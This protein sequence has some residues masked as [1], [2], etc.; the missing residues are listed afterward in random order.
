[1]NDAL[2]IQNVWSGTEY[3]HLVEWSLPRHMRYCRIH[4]WDYRLEYGDA[5][6]RPTADPNSLAGWAKPHMILN[7]FDLYEYVVWLEPDAFILDTNINLKAAFEGGAPC[8][9]CL[10][11][12]PFR[13]INVGVMYWHRCDEARQMLNDWIATMPGEAPWWEQLTFNHLAADWP[14]GWVKIL[15]AR[16]NSVDFINPSTQPVIYA[17]HAYQGVIPRLEKFKAASAEWDK[18][19]EFRLVA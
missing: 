3:I 7:A 5:I 16:W 19:H 11:D 9:A 8:G 10:M 1:M 17:T 18:R 15:P 2:I 6:P 14:D 13:H 12:N 4:R